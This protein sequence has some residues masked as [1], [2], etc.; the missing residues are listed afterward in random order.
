MKGQLIRQLWRA[1][2]AIGMNRKVLLV[3]TLTVVPLLI[4]LALSLGKDPRAI[5]SPLLDAP[6][7][8]FSLVDLDGQRVDL[9]QLR[10]QPVMINFWATWCQP[11]VVEHPVLQRVSRRYQGREHFI[12][13][14]Y[15]DD[16]DLIRSFI[17][18]RGG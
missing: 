14:G 11:C 3:G 15:Q 1:A 7:P 10:G 17:A 2:G 12:G 13:I 6:A 8:G 9:A 5:E 16:P 18:Q 4:F